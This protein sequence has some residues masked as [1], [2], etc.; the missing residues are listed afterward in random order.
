MFGVHEANTSS[1]S[2]T[3]WLSTDNANFQVMAIR[4]QGWSKNVYFKLTSS[5][6]PNP[7][8]ELTSSV[9]FDVYDN[10]EWNFS[11]RLK[12][13]NFP[14]TNLVSGATDYTYLLEFQGYNTVNDTIQ[15]SFLLTSS[16]SKTVGSNFLNAAKRIYAGARRTNITGA[17]LQQNDVLTT[18]VKYWTRYIDD[19]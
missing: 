7:F 2:D 8:P 10:Q 17:V 18:N 4:D 5:V 14:L 3:T 11:V 12:P 6:S 16:V 15:D 9:F 1:A 19:T 13:S